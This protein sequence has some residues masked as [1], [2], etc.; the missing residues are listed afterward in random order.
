MSQP[1]YFFISVHF[2]RLFDPSFSWFIHPSTTT[3]QTH[4]FQDIHDTSPPS[5]S[6]REQG[7]TTQ[8]KRQ[9]APNLR[10]KAHSLAAMPDNIE[11]QPL[12]TSDPLDDDQPIT[13]STTPRKPNPH[14]PKHNSL[15]AQIERLGDMALSGLGPVLISLAFLLLSV[16]IFCFYTVFLPFHHPW[17]EG[18]GISGNWAYIFHWIWATYLVWGILANYYLAVRTPAGSVLDGVSSSVICTIN[19]RVASLSCTGNVWNLTQKCVV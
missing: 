3:V 5:P 1:C 18:Q 7:Q 10:K 11:F 17:N 12:A 8:S 15:A 13:T 9:E 16:T 6:N 14:S 19:I 2:L 4:L